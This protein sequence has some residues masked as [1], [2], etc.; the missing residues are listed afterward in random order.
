VGR[1]S[2]VINTTLFLRSEI[3][4]ERLLMTQNAD[5][6]FSNIDWQGKIF[7]G[8]WSNSS[9]GQHKV[10][11]PATGNALA[12]VGVANAEDVAKSAASAK[13]AQTQWANRAPQERAAVLRRAT[14]SGGTSM[15]SLVGWFGKQVASA[16]N[17]NLKFYKLSI[18]R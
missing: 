4:N 11:E 3:Q 16:Q 14:C 1:L 18:L 9:G 2:A 8:R 10:I 13:A 15:R 6:L 17:Q 7:T 5:G 12:T